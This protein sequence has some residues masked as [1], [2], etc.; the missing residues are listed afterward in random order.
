[1]QRQTTSS[2]RITC[3]FLLAIAGSMAMFNP[4]LAADRGMAPE[5]IARLRTVEEAVIS[6]SGEAVAYVLSVPRNPFSEDN[7]RAWRELHVVGSDGASRPY[8]AGHQQVRDLAWSP[9][10]RRLSFRAKRDDDEE[11]AVW[12]IPVDG[13]E[14]VRLV[15]HSE[16]IKAYSWSPDGRQLAFLATAEEPAEHAELRDKGFDQK[17]FEEDWRPTL[18]WV[19]EL[20]SEAPPRQITVE[21]SAF[22]VYWSPDGQRLAVVVAPS[23]L[24]DDSY[25]RKQIRIVD[26]AET[27][28]GAALG[29]VSVA[30]PGKLG[31]LVW[32]PD[33]SYLAMISAADLNDPKEGRLLV[34]PASGGELRDLL[35]GVK[36]HVTD[37]AWQ[38]SSRIVYLLDQG[39][40][41]RLGVVALDGDVEPVARVAAAAAWKKISV[42]PGGALALVGSTPEHPAEVFWSAA[43]SSAVRRLTD[44]NPWLAE[45]RMASQEVVRYQAR[46]GLK[47]EGILI[48]PLDSQAGQRYPLVLIA[49]GG[50]ESHFS[51]DWQTNYSR[52]G[53]ILAARG[54]AVFYPNY[55]GSTG[56]GVAFSKL[57]Q[58]DPAGREFD[59]LVD[60][61][62]HLVQAGL[63]DRDKVGITGG[64]Y[65][66]YASAWG[67]TYYTERFAAAVM[68]VGISDKISKL[69]TSDIPREL[70]LVHDRHWPW[71]DWQLFLERSPI[72]YVEQAR[73]P[74]LILHGEDDPRVHPSQSMELH[75]HLKTHGKTPVR[76]VFYPGEG[77]GNRK[78]AGRYDYT[79]RLL[80]WMEHY[81][82]GEGG[83]P[84]PPRIDYPWGDTE[85]E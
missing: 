30:N 20:G 22:E 46:D 54:F 7:G 21:G 66:G 12:E 78:A 64:S 18:V 5:D 6:P 59:D 19:S 9:D 56:R 32:G 81:L 28:D 25:M 70:F 24:V 40:E 10:G 51:N 13:G 34:V 67:A 8:I 3:G 65:G 48:R 58:G 23:P 41:K 62:D 63:V 37:L 77:H 43:D 57:S 35:P 74:I 72:Y 47:L 33:G 49:H 26:L 76:L 17:V 60:G 39:V 52:P 1:M 53:Q 79:L 27:E 31:K 29:V 45:A 16:G 38:N 55:R 42:A 14:A 80:R 44:S 85:I 84:P 71:D 11:N 50:P 82:Q 2:F 61:V 83:E 36:G 4:L 73:T 15:E 68:F 69:G 75:R